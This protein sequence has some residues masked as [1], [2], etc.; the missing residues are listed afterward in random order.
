MGTYILLVNSTDHGA[1]NLAEIPNRQ[2]AS[3]QTAAKLGIVRKA[4]YMT[5]GPYDFVQIIEAPDDEAVAK[6]V[7]SVNS[8]GNVRTTTMRAFDEP[9]HIEF[10]K[11]LP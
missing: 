1:K 11:N 8:K 10:L 2:E 5:L 6:Y 4:V 7:L 9:E 3:R